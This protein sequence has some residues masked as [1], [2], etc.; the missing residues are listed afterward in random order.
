MTT[1]RDIITRA[2]RASGIIGL[3][4]T[5]TAGEADYGM[6]SLQSMFDTWLAGGMFGRLNDVYTTTAYTAKEGDR[7]IAS[8]SPTI[9]IPATYDEDG[10]AGSDRT[11]YDLSVIEVKN[12]AARNVWLYDR[13]NWVD[14]VAL[15]LS[16]TCPLSDRGA[17][18]LAC[19]LAQEL[20]GPFT[21]QLPQSVISSAFKF[22]QAISYKLGSERPAR[23]AEYF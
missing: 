12:G 10:E 7:V 4:A 5:P 19:C 6:V 9:T 18:G 22:K 16:D 20:S 8:G 3:S 15:E 17:H 11:P 2:Y 23:T 13:S 1:C 21:E 14:L